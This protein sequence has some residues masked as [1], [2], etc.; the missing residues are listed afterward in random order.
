M[1][2]TGYIQ[3][4]GE[5][6]FQ[7]SVEMDEVEKLERAWEVDEVHEVDLRQTTIISKQQ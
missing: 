3:L 4:Q 2:S 7:L 1:R 5:H 6:K